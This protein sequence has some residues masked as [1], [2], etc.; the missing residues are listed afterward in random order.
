MKHL[1]NVSY[2]VVSHESAENGDFEETGF[3][4]QN[5]HLNEIS[6]VFGYTPKRCLEDCGTW[7]SEI[8]GTTDYKTGDNRRLTLHPPRNITKASYSRL[9]RFFCGR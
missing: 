3:E 5:I 2:E 6:H 7:F 1:F 8:D 9:K 4:A